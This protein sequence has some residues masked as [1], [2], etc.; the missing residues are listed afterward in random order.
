MALVAENKLKQFFGPTATSESII[1][2]SVLPFLSTL[3]LSLDVPPHKDSKSDSL[4]EL[5]S[6]STSSSSIS[7]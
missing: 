5:L 4:D 3:T 6:S 2:N 1:A 7:I